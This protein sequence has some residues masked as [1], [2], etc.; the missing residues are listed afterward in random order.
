MTLYRAAL[1]PAAS[2]AVTPPIKTIKTHM[3]TARARTRRP[4]TSTVAMGAVKSR[5]QIVLTFAEPRSCLANNPAARRSSEIRLF[6][7]R[8]PRAGEAFEVVVTSSLL[9][10]GHGLEHLIV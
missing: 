6:Y 1:K 8:A 7:D 4:S 2:G 9:D 10:D 3:F 5:G